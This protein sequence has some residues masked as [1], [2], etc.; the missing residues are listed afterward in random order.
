[1]RQIKNSRLPGYLKKH[2]WLLLFVSVGMLVI[3][4]VTIGYVMSERYWTVYVQNTD[5]YYRSTEQKTR[6]IIMDKNNSALS[7]LQPL[8]DNA[9]KICKPATL[10]GWQTGS[11]SIKAKRDRCEE[12]ASRLRAF[13]LK[14]KSVTIHLDSQQQVADMVKA[15]EVPDE[16]TEDGFV[17]TIENWKGLVSK[18]DA[19]KVPDTMNETNRVAQERV[20]SMIVSWQELQSAHLTKNQANYEIAAVKVA[21]EY[22]ALGQIASENTASLERL[23]NALQLS[24]SETFS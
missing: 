16:I 7:S 21:S 17:K 14:L 19:L 4:I 23:A 5:S 18:I 6:G 13:G 12:N 10:Y 2:T 20:R 24:F 11:D 8:Y 15:I 22:S 3:M 1:M 9:D